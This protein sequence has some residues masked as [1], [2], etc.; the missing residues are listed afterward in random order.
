[1]IACAS[2]WIMRGKRAPDTACVRSPPPG[3]DTD[4]SECVRPEAAKRH[5]PGSQQVRD[6]SPPPRRVTRLVMV[7]GSSRIPWVRQFVA[8]ATGVQPS[9][10]VDPE[11][12]V[13]LGAAMYAGM[14]SGHIAGIELADGAYS[15]DLHGRSSGFPLA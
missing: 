12:C 13:A 1:M 10:D 11:E 2:C 6:Y 4:R 9:P 7:G 5:I 3:A 14:L 8:A 15:Q